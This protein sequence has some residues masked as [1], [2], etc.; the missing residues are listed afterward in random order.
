M[1]ARLATQHGKRS[2]SIRLVLRRQNFLN[3]YLVNEVFPLQIAQMCPLFVVGQICANPIDH[4]HNECA[5]IHVH[6]ISPTNKFVRT[7]PVRRDYRDRRLGQAH[8]TGSSGYI[9]RLRHHIDRSLNYFAD[10]FC[11]LAERFYLL[12]HKLGLD[13]DNIFYTLRL[14]KFLHET[15]SSGNVFRSVV[16]K[17]SIQMRI[18]PREHGHRILNPTKTSLRRSHVTQQGRR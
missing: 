7:V 9:E 2:L 8:R 11:L 16:Q 17:F 15:N 1:N 18:A 14:A 5:V 13:F 6:P 3:T 10:G 12:F 4:D